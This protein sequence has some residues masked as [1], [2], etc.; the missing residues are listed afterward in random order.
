MRKTAAYCE[1]CSILE[2]EIRQLR[3]LLAPRI[4]WPK[5]WKLQESP[6]R[7]LDA[8]WRAKGRMVPFDAL[9]AAAGDRRRVETWTRS[10]ISVQIMHIRKRIP[11]LTIKNDCG[12]GYYLTDNDIR[13]LSDALDGT[14]KQTLTENMERSD[15]YA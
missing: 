15:G 9:W 6:K 8:L 3:E 13:I 10:L 7:M 2:E 5:E 1:R 12:M 4:E 11:G 14:K